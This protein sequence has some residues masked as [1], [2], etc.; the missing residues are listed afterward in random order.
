MIRKALF[1]CGIL[2]SLLYVAT[3]VLGPM[4]WEGYSSMS[5]TISELYAIDAPSRSLLLP[6]GIAYDVLLIAFGIGVWGAAGPKRGLRVTAAMLVVIGA[7][8][9]W[10]PPM[11]L[12]GAEKSLT[13]T[14]HIVWAGVVVVATLLAI[15]FAATA[16]GK[17]FR[18]Y[19]IA[20][21]V[22]LFVSGGLTGLYGPRIGA[23]LPTP[24]AGL[25]ERINLA[26]YLLW[27][28]VLAIELLRVPQ[29]ASKVI[30]PTRHARDAFA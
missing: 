8:G 2:T 5:Q 29:S 22:I 21:I 9:L 16:F 25:T 27:V 10:W 14:L 11:H 24:W 17:W 7:I 18:L 13:D 1:V 12:R 15:G 6:I 26:G 19:S 23:N 20:T 3:L 30:A 4:R 28:I